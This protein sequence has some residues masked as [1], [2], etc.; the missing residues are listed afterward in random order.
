MWSWYSDPFGTD[1]PNENPA[2]GGTFKYNLRFPGQLYDSH[3]GLNQNYFR[4]YDPAIGR[5]VESDPIGLEGGAN[6][7]SYVDSIP[8]LLGDPAGL[9][10]WCWFVMSQG[11]MFCR[12]DK[13]G[14][15]VHDSTGWVSGTKN[16]GCQNN[17]TDKCM[18]LKNA[19]PIPTGIY[20][21]GGIPPGKV[22]TSTL[23]RMLIPSSVNRIQTR[24]DL[25]THF[26]PNP[27]TCS[28]GCIAN[29]SMSTLRDFTKLMDTNPGTQITVL[30]FDLD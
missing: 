11:Y 9:K 30:G 5:Y 25:Q 29:P 22:G 28:I 19:G 18:R 13:D 20:V 21:S 23:R 8:T 10:P 3:A 1:L 14:S 12:D 16:S 15:F 17:P 26:C 2:A 24:T 7:Y 6:T 27:A 4:D